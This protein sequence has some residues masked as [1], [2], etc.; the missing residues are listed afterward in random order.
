MVAAEEV[1]DELAELA[2]VEEGIVVVIVLRK[3][4]HHFLSQL[5]MVVLEGLKL[6]KGGFKFALAEICWVDHGRLSIYQKQ[7]D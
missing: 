7:S 2:P 3:V 5:L 4:L 6:G 1:T